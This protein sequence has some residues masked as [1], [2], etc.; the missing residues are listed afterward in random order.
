MH[1][2]LFIGL[3]LFSGEFEAQSVSQEGASA[4]AP[5]RRLSIE[6]QMNEGRAQLDAHRYDEAIQT[7]NHVLE[8]IPDFGPALANR[9][10]A[11]AWTNRLDEATRDVD[12]AA[13]TMSDTAVVHRVRGYIAQRRSD[14]VTANAELSRSLELEP[15]NQLALRS[16]AF[17]FQRAGNHAAALADANT[18]I[19]AHPDDP[20]AYVTRADLLIGQQ[21]HPQAEAEARRLTELFPGNAY[22]L[23]SAARIYDALA[24]RDRAMAAINEAIRLEPDEAYYLATRAAI[25][26]RDDLAGRRADL[27]AALAAYPG[28][29][30]IL[31]NLG[32]V[33]FRER[34]WS[35]AVARFSAVLA[36][37]PRDFGLLAYRSMARLNAGQRALAE[38]DF[39]T[40]MTASSGADDFSLVCG[41]F[42]KEGVALDWSMEACN[43]AVSL[44]ANESTYRAH[45]GLAELRLGQLEAALADYNAAI[46]ADPRRADG[47][48]GRALVLRRRGDQQA[49]AADH[50]RALAI[51]EGIDEEYQQYGLNDFH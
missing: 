2:I 49:S 37:E 14:D 51:D 41:V 20:D 25:R 10:L 43:R 8:R 45:R 24:N 3:L 1:A 50:A 36:L 39:R 12:A 35:D 27:E 19:D 48:Y 15:G 40:A 4:S 13:R 32:L 26:R 6:E 23:A 17:I 16:R 47:F 46:Q 29:G 34:K 18:D 22:A 5:G 44:N 38:Q 42:A 31:T 21:Q 30:D 28:D 11:Y 33:D 7:F 9:A